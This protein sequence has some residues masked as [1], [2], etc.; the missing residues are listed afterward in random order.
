[1]MDNEQRP[2]HKFDA[3]AWA[4]DLIQSVWTRPKVHKASPKEH[5]KIL[6]QRLWHIKQANVLD[7]ACGTGAAIPFLDR[8]NAY[9]GLD[10]SSAMLQQAKKKAEKK[11]FRQADFI[12]GSAAHPALPENAFDL[13]LMDTAL[14]LIPEYEQV[15]AQVERVLAP[16]GSFV[17]ITP[18]MGFC[19]AFDKAW[20]TMSKKHQVNAF[21]TKALSLVCRQN[22]LEFTIFAQ[23]GGL[24]YFDAHKNPDESAHFGLAVS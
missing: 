22:N 4:Y 23:N 21:T 18:A 15:L 8:S 14:H 5:K 11:S 24:L 10:L 1:M 7:L 20:D 17:C 16:D 12:H 13:V 6:E 3:I 2:V 9:T 19:T